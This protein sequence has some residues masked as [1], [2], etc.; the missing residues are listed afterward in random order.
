MKIYWYR[1][2]PSYPVSR[3]AATVLRDGD[4]LL[5]QSLASHRGNP[6][7]GSPSHYRALRNLPE[8]A[9]RSEGSIRWVASRATTYLR[10]VYLRHRAATGGDHDICHVFALNY[11][12]DPLTLP[13]LAGSAPLVSTVHDV[14]PHEKRLPEA[15]Q[16]EL[17]RRLY[18]A[19][20]T[21]VVAHPSMREDLVSRFEVDPE[22]VEVIPLPLEQAVDPATPEPP[23]P[24]TVLFFGHFRRNKG[25][26]VMLRAIEAIEEA[27]IR[28]VFAGRGVS[29]LEQRVREAADKDSR[30]RAEIGFVSSA[31]LDE[32][33][34]NAHLVVLPYTEFASQSGVLGNAYSHLVPVVATEVGALAVSVAEDGSGWVI[35]PGSWEALAESITSAL[36]DD[37]GRTRARAAIDRVRACRSYRAVGT[38]HRE[39]YAKL[40]EQGRSFAG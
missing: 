11:F 5:L 1:P 2:Y 28:F 27:Q 20:G 4:E 37:E 33:F 14:V 29:D 23:G 15:V 31:R 25:I 24:P 32:L 39:L 7:T 8:P 9:R 35:T 36:A 26:E 30:I 34:G 10:R 22:K 13:R 21:L 17:L 16:D 12:I 18:R 19:A 38:A 40:V 3:L 6:L